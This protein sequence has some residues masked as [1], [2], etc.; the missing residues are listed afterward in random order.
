MSFSTEAY[1][2]IL[3]KWKRHFCTE[4]LS[5]RSIAP[6]SGSEMCSTCQEKEARY[7]CPKCHAKYCSINC[8]RVHDIKSPNNEAKVGVC[9]EA[10]YRGRV[11]EVNRI[12]IQDKAN[13]NKMHEILT[14]QSPGRGGNH[15]TAFHVDEDSNMGFLTDDE[16][17]E[18]A[19]CLDSEI[20]LIPEHLR[21]RFEN[22]VK[23]GIL[24]NLIE[25]YHPFWLPKYVNDRDKLA[26]KEMEVDVDHEAQK[27]ECVNSLDERILSIRPIYQL[28]GKSN[29]S[30]VQLQYNTCDLL[31][32]TASML[33]IYNGFINHEDAGTVVIQNSAVLFSDARFSSVSQV[34][35]SSNE[36]LYK[37]RSN[38]N[39]SLNWKVLVRDLSYIV[40]HKRMVLKC[41]F[42]T[43]DALKE[44]IKYEKNSSDISRSHRVL[45]P[46]ERN[47]LTANQL[48]LVKKK[49]EFYISWCASFW[50]STIEEVLRIE[51]LQWLHDWMR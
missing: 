14:Q 17:V 25:E 33:R 28:V 43:L 51:I 6:T 23:A 40:K 22:A 29:A 16:L 26:G 18:L 38:E 15:I 13:K 3:P 47:L 4:D 1:P 7:R 32:S 24:S 34:L 8:Y 31:Y 35:M 49:V 20:A 39:Y 9:T 19:D 41:L 11:S 5:P 50:D 42:C 30:K 10:F 27:I 46:T 21:S 44:S 48:K 36:Q 12:E 37:G 2:R 45:I